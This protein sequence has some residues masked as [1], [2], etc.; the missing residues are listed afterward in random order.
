MIPASAR[1]AV[2]TDTDGFPA[3][4][5]DHDAADTASAIKTF[6]PPPST[7]DRNAA[8]RASASTRFTSS[9]RCAWTSQSAGPPTLNVVNGAS[10]TLRCTRSGVTR[11]RQRIGEVVAHAAPAIES[12]ASRSRRAAIASSIE[13]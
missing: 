5:A 12:S 10:G 7:V 11:R 3:M 8:S 13:Q 4:N 1:D 2:R 6:D 9:A